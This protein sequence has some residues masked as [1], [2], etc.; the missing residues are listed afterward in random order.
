MS[1]LSAKRIKS[2]FALAAAV[3]VLAWPGA[4]AARYPEIGG[5]LGQH[6]ALGSARYQ[7]L[8][9]TVFDAELWGAGQEFSWDRPFAL[10]LTY[11]RDIAEVDLVQRSLSGM[12]ARTRVADRERLENALSACFAEVRSGDRFTGVSLTDNDARFYLNGRQTCAISWPGFRRAFFGIWLDARG[13]D[14]AFSAQLT[15]AAAAQTQRS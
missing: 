14:R 6:H 13:R 3:V 1:V 4:A 12:A 8:A 11:R 10:S 9:W 2:A 5:S 7:V 15:G